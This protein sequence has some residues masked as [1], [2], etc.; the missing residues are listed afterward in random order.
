MI[1][2]YD[3]DSEVS[4]AGWIVWDTDTEG[5]HMHNVKGW[6]R[7]TKKTESNKRRSWAVVMDWILYL[8][9]NLYVEA[10]ASSVMVF[11]SKSFGRLVICKW[12]HEDG[13]CMIGF[14]FFLNEEER[15]EC[16]LFL[17]HVYED[18]SRRQPS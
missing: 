2:V 9:P 14:F 18:T 16:T 8:P 4:V 10:L 6:E 1:Y 5:F 12:T 3:Q 11:G 7:K 17:H 15:L 13:A